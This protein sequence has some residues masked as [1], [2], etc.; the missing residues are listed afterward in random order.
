MHIDI[1]LISIILYG[2]TPGKQRL[3]R[4]AE[5][6]RKFTQQLYTSLP[7]EK[8]SLFLI[9]GRIYNENEYA[10]PDNG[11]EFKTML[12]EYSDLT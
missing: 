4:R 2:K 3:R 12:I 9:Y 7:V 6:C 5:N 1:I 8:K 10:P 11:Q